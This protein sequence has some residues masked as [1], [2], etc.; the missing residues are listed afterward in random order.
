MRVSRPSSKIERQMLTVMQYCGIC[1][2][3]SSPKCSQHPVQPELNGTSH[4]RPRGQW[5]VVKARWY[6]LTQS[7]D[8]ESEPRFSSGP[9]GGMRGGFGGGMGMRG[10][11]GGQMGGGYGGGY[12]GGMGGPM[13]G[14]MGGGMG[15]G[16][17]RQIYVSNV[18]STWSSA[19][20]N[21]SLTI[22]SFL[23]L[24]AGKI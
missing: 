10:G 14:P 23:T 8:R 19:R 11:M 21:G 20:R 3:R 7:Q 24:S 17:G 9:P 4:L 2:E 15:G 6:T 18:G 12:G 13:G 22:S 5:S 16:G 1:H